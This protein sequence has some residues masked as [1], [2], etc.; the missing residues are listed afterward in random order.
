MLAQRTVPT[1]AAS[2]ASIAFPPVPQR[3]LRAFVLACCLLLCGCVSTQTR[4]AKDDTGQPLT[5]GGSVVLVEP[6][7]ELYEVLAGAPRSRARPGPTRPGGCIRR[8]RERSS[9]S[10]A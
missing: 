6:D 5:I 7:M 1:A 10:A 2:R 3:L 9:P 8:W 4:V